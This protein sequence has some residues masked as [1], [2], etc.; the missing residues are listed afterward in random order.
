MYQ[1]IVP[2]SG[3]GLGPTI[4][5]FLSKLHSPRGFF[6]TVFWNSVLKKK[7]KMA[8]TQSQLPVT[9]IEAF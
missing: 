6:G 7:R 1:V 3:P 2:I 9:I 5:S 4:G 8:V